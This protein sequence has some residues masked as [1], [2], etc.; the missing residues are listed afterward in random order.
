MSAS[1][2]LV[3][4]TAH[5]VLEDA[6]RDK[7]QRRAQATGSLGELEPLAVRLGLIQNT[8]K[9]RF[10]HPRLLV[11]AADHGLAVDGVGAADNARE[12][13]S[14]AQLVVSL[15]ASQLPASVL[16]RLHGLDLLVVDAGL[17]DRLAPHARLLARKIAHGTR[18]ARIGAAM[19]LEQAHAAIRAGIEIADALPGNLVACAGIGVGSHESAALLLSRLGPAPLHDFVVSGPQMGEDAIASLMTLLHGVQVRHHDSA[20]PVEALAAFGGFEIAMM[21]GL[22]LQA[23]NRRQTI[24][25]DGMAACAAMLVASRIAP[26]VTDYCVFCRSS[27]HH[28]LDR[29]LALFETTALLDLGLRSLDGTGAAIAFALL[30]SAA[31]LLTEVADGEDPG[32]TLPADLGTSGRPQPPP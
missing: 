12:R 18:N 30:R 10:E 27:A 1:R 5:S 14:T 24:M 6:L 8:L 29:A 13:R 22:M 11:F 9:P 20:D 15:L 16:A 21:V 31:A 19:S 3:S 32:P 7:L 4:P 26:A 2:S 25:V 23:G 17:A 28:G